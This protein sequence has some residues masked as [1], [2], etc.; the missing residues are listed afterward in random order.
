MHSLRRLHRRIAAM[1]AIDERPALYGFFCEELFTSPREAA[2]T[3]GRMAEFAA[4]WNYRL[5]KVFTEKPGHA[6]T[7]FNKLRDAVRQDGAA[8]V[9]PTVDH[10]KPYGDVN[11][12]AEELRAPSGHHVMRSEPEDH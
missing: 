12:L 3:R 8:V 1:T 9:V 7:A 10:L 2:D 5:T 6:P 4:R 11:A